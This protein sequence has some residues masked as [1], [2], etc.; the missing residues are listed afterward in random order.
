MIY[1]VEPDDEAMSMS[2][3]ELKSRRLTDKERNKLP[4]RLGL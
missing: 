1:D 4:L 3:P 2:V